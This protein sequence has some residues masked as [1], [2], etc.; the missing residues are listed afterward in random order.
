MLRRCVPFS[1]EEDVQMRR[2]TALFAAA[3]LASAN[4]ALADGKTIAVSGDSFPS[5][6]GAA[7]N[8]DLATELT[9]NLTGCMAA[10]VE[11]VNCR[12]LNG[13]A[14]STEL[15]REEFEGTLDGEP[16][17]FDTLYTFEATWPSGSC[18]EPDLKEEIT[19]GCVHY[20]SGENAVGTV[21]FYDVMPVVGKGGT[22]FFYEGSI[23]LG[24]ARPAG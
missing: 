3:M 9:G 15:G 16:I 6:C 17:K 7:K 20:I 23:T 21:R 24:A 19:G 4:G 1:P 10:F 12:E 14:F 8:A 13:F 22:H 2:I 18:P 5:D 11:H